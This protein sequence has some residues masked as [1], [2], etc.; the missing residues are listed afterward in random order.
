MSSI[1]TISC[2]INELMKKDEDYNSKIQNHWDETHKYHRNVISIDHFTK[3]Y[4]MFVNQ[5]ATRNIF[6][7]SMKKELRHD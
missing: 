6:C 1:K 2:L 5:I 4:V 7:Q 3:L